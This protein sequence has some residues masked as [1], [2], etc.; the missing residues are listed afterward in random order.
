MFIVVPYM[1]NTMYHI[2]IHC[3]TI[4]YTHGGDCVYVAYINCYIQ[5]YHNM[6]P[7]HLELSKEGT[8]VISMKT[9]DVLSKLLSSNWVALH[10]GCTGVFLIFCPHH[11]LGTSLHTAHF[12]ADSEGVSASMLWLHSHECQWSILPNLSGVVILHLPP[13]EEPGHSG[14]GAPSNLHCQGDLLSLGTLHLTLVVHNC[15]WEGC[16]WF[17]SKCNGAHNRNKQCIV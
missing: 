6:V 1:E 13:I 9:G 7:A 2:N 4:S 11:Q 17:V 12:V 8:V 5:R 14:G 10:S 3:C 16:V 15:G